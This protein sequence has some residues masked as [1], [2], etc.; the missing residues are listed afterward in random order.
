M[1]KTI[2]A[3]LLLQFV[4]LSNAQ[5]VRNEGKI[6]VSG[7]YMIISGSYQNE[8]TGGIVLDGIIQVSGNWTN[9]GTTNVIET[10]GTNGEVVFNGTGT[11]TIGGTSSNVFDFERIT[12]N[13]G[14]VTEVQAG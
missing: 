13:S 3:I 6:N 11:Q 2:I 9:N 5:V 7:G 4:L 10:P 8:S 1:K 14:S 12:I